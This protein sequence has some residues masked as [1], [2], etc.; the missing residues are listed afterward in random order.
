MSEQLKELEQQ[1]K[2]S[3]IALAK[4]QKNNNVS[5][6]LLFEAKQKEGIPL[7]NPV[8][9]RERKE[10]KEP[11]EPK[12]PKEKKVKAPKVPKEKKEPAKKR[13]RPAATAEKK[14]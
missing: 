2:R 5:A 11:K 1:Y 6:Y 10:K 9:K 3:Q 14:N 7:V 8:K 4:A 12:A 13:G